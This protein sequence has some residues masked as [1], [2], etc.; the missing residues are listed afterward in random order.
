MDYTTLT[1]ILCSYIRST[2][3]IA[4]YH[5]KTIYS[6]FPLQQNGIVKTDLPVNM[7]LRSITSSTPELT[8]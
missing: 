3:K 8:I 6:Y 1:R 7:F 4:G 2:H 5:Y